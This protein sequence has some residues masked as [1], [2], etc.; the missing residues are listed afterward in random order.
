VSSTK[1]LKEE[2][3]DQARESQESMNKSKLVNTGMTTFS[4]KL[5]DTKEQADK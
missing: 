3:A 1:D 2:N 5:L 4:F